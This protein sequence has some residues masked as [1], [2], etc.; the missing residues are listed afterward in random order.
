MRYEISYR[1]GP[2]IGNIYEINSICFH[3]SFSDNPYGYIWKI[4]KSYHK[5]VK[6][7]A[8]LSGNFKVWFTI[9]GKKIF[10]PQIQMFLLKYSFLES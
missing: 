9:D 5:L 10:R 8:L 3:T 6:K 1:Y 7:Y 2:R 4:N